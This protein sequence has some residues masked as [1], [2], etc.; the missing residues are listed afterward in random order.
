MT[1]CTI[2]NHENIQIQPDIILN[3]F[4]YLKNN[5]IAL[6]L[7]HNN[8]A[9]YL[10]IKFNNQIAE[11]GGYLRNIPSS[12]FK[13]AIH[14]IFN[15]YQKINQIQIKYTLH[16]PK[17]C[18]FNIVDHYDLKIPYNL[19]NFTNK[20]SKNEKNT[21]KRKINKIKKELGEYS[22]ND[23]SNKDIQK[24]QKRFFELKK[25]SVD[26]DDGFD[27]DSYFD[28]YY[29]T[30]IYTLEIDNIVYAMILSCEQGSCVYFENTTYDAR[31][32]SYS[33]GTVLYYHYIEKLIEKGKEGL[34]LGGGQ[35]R[36]KAMFSSNYIPVTYNCYYYRNFF[37]NFV[38]YLYGLALNSLI[39]VYHIFLK[40]IDSFNK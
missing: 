30:N 25:D 24:L 27:K 15:N 16:R 31:L 29:V 37:K 10:T 40:F 11:I 18:F 36:Y 13:T 19:D 28:N 33:L 23:Y 1:T 14:F 32:S 7:E 21:I 26:I 6:K 8:D 9:Y 34:F 3:R 17:S 2:I 20:M 38:F 5:N 35:Y 39:A 22:V 12:V 4:D